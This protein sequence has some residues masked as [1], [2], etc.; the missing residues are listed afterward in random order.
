MTRR[1]TLTAPGLTGRLLTRAKIQER[2]KLD[3]I[4]LLEEKRPRPRI[5][6]IHGSWGSA[7]LGASDPEYGQEGPAPKSDSARG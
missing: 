7:A 3:R 5:N 2:M 6:L 4:R 1:A